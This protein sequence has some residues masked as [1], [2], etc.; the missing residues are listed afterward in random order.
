MR[1]QCPNRENFCEHVLDYTQI[2]RSRYLDVN[3]QVKYLYMRAYNLKYTLKD[4]MGI[5]FVTN[6]PRNTIFLWADKKY[7]K[8]VIRLG[9]LLPQYIDEI[10]NEDEKRIEFYKLYF[11]LLLNSTLNLRI[12]FFREG[13]NIPLQGNN[14]RDMKTQLLQTIIQLCLRDLR[15]LISNDNIFHNTIHRYKKLDNS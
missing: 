3:Q 2:I 11:L 9:L 7:D 12:R 5:L 1:P 6:Q 14:I 13:A 8:R 15:L 10:P 4:L